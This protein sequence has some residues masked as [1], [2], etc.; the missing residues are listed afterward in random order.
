MIDKAVNE[1][2][3]EIRKKGLKKARLKKKTS[4]WKEEDTLEGRVVDTGVVLL[5]TRGC[6]WGR[7]SGCTM[8]G[9]VYDAGDMNDS[10][11]ANVFSETAS[12]LGDVKYLKIFTSGSFFDRREVSETLSQ[13]I[14][15]VINEMG[16]EQLQVE[17][18]PEYIK[19]DV[20]SLA[21]EELDSRL[22]VGI[23]LETSS[24]LVREKC[25]NKGFSF[26]DYEEAVQICNSQ[27]AL[28]KTYLLL[29]PPFMIEREAISDTVKSAKD[30]EL[31]GSTKI[32]I[33]PMNIQNRTLVELLWKRREYRPP[34]LWS[35]VD[36]LQ[37]LAENGLNVPVL[38]HPT[39]GGSR[40]GV[41]NCGKCDSEVLKAIR[42]FSTTQDAKVL[43]SLD[44]SCKNHW[45][46]Y[47]DLE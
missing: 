20:L 13:S 9:Y 35:L 17:S 12:A 26:A 24:D 2:V 8:C 19:N 14:I 32:S 34:W 42:A 10:K 41:H 15:Q 1:T 16:V 5:P 46:D 37:Q 30:A 25:V 45:R 36:V 40:R 31:A 7:I 23:G 28:V 33:N 38:S 4:Y 18:R 6:S 22:E 47:L 43:T 21:V 29:K 44:C 39:G 3:R 11:L 27:D